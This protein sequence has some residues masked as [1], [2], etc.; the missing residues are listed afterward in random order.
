MNLD[1]RPWVETI[2][3]KLKVQCIQHKGTLSFENI[4]WTY[5]LLSKF[6]DKFW[7]VVNFQGLAVSL[8]TATSGTKYDTFDC[9]DCM[10]IIISVIKVFIIFFSH[11]PIANPW[12]LTT[13]HNLSTN[14]DTRPWV[15]TIFAKLNVPLCW[16][17]WTPRV[18]PRVKRDHIRT[19][20]SSQT[21]YKLQAF[22]ET[23]VKSSTVRYFLHMWIWIQTICRSNYSVFFL[24]RVHI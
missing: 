6:I 16:M 22:S 4:V 8:K 15:E 14:L 18:P 7:A 20:S 24:L 5:S 10:C 9:L 12:K 17:H 1:T 11:R 23:S 13:A 3:A 2:F 21:P 19:F